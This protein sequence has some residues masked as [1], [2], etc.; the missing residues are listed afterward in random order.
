[1]IIA[2]TGMSPGR[3]DGP[4]REPAPAINL[5]NPRLHLGEQRR[6][7]PRS[8]GSHNEARR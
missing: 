3:D 5:S 1:V 4:S 8:N 7:A 2:L 6:S